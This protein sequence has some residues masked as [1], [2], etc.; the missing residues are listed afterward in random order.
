MVQ[1]ERALAPETTDR[2]PTALTKRRIVLEA[3]KPCFTELEWDTRAGRRESPDAPW[4]SVQ[5]T[6]P[7]PAAA[8][9]RGSADQR[10]ACAANG[11]CS[12]HDS[13]SCYRRVDHCSAERVSAFQGN[14]SDV[15][16][17][18]LCQKRT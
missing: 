17:L 9:S 3:S 1:E 16:G 5:R 11:M 2:A 18:S 14:V 10:I 8:S 4:D 6:A 7:I 12:R 15:R 13:S